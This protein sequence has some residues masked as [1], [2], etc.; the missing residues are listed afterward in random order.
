MRNRK[1]RDQQQHGTVVHDKETDQDRHAHQTL[2]E[3]M[4]VIRP[5]SRGDS[6]MRLKRLIMTPHRPGPATIGFGYIRL[7]NNRP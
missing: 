5:P 3:I 7:R 6:G 4:A 1:N 2:G